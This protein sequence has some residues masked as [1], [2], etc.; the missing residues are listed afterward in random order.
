MSDSLIPSDP[1][2]VM[3]IRNVT[4]EI[5]TLSVPFRRFGRI[6]IGGRATIGMLLRVC[7]CMR[8]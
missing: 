8:V 4:K 1:E 6:N 2:K 3:V 5:M 7:D